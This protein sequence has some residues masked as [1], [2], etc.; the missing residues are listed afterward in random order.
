MN[1]DFSYIEFQI[2]IGQHTIFKR[3]SLISDIDIYLSLFPRMS[4]ALNQAVTKEFKQVRIA[5]MMSAT[6]EVMTIITLIKTHLK[7]SLPQEFTPQIAVETFVLADL[8]V[9]VTG[10][11]ATQPYEAEEP[12]VLVVTSML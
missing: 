5:T 6:L 12:E 11:E 8:H 9:G 10:L 3:K 7:V 1:F 2:L 4:L